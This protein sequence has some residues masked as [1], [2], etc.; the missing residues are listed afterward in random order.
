MSNSR[1]L[2][3]SATYHKLFLAKHTTIPITTTVHH[4]TTLPKPSFHWKGRHSLQDNPDMCSSTVRQCKT[5]PFSTC[6]LQ[7][8]Y[9]ID[10]N[11]PSPQTAA[12]HACM[13][14]AQ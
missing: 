7:G 10:N 5:N 8:P 6:K 2:N 12:H 14:M 3:E 9:F 11:F 1:M 4:A 13:W